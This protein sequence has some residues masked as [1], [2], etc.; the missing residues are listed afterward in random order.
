MTTTLARAV[1]SAGS[2]VGPVVST[3]R[4]G[5]VPRPSAMR[6][7]QPTWSWKVEESA[8]STSGSM[9]AGGVHGSTHAGSSSTAPT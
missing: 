8:T 7:K 1:I 2:I 6:C 3:A 4:T 9:P 5:I